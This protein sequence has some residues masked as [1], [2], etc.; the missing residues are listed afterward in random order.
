MGN[1]AKICIEPSAFEWLGWY[2]NAMPVW[3]S[4]QQLAD[5]KFSVDVEHKPFVSANSLHIDE[6]VPDYYERCHK[7]TQHILRKHENEGGDILIVAHAGS[8]DTF[9]R[10]LQGKLP[11][12]SQEMHLILN[13]FT[14]CCICC[15]AE[16]ASSKKWSLVEPPIPP[17]HEF[18]WKVLL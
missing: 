8:L 1:G 15:L 6:S 3:M 7:L 14:Y 12:S 9:T 13:S 17:L 16:D 5:G 4:T 10:R 11:R 2:K 18:D